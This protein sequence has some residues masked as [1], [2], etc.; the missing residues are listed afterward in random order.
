MKDA[1][2][3]GDFWALVEGG[4]PVAATAIHDGHELRREVEQCHKLG[5][6]DRLREEDPYTGRIASVVDTHIIPRRSRFEVDLNRPRE[7]AVYLSPADAWGLDLWH[8][9]PS[10]DFIERSLSYHDAFYREMDRILKGMTREF[11]AFVVYDVHSYNHRRLGPDAEPEHPDENPEVNIGTETMDRA[12]W[13]PVVDRFINDLRAYEA[14]G[15][16]LDVRE[17]VKFFGRGNLARRTHRLHPETG[18]VL[19]IE[20]RKSFMDD[21]LARCSRRT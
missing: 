20:F 15:R 21:G 6:A 10:P 9:T 1:H 3:G 12:R 14:G 11:G 13:A 7:G 17:N 2:G 8:E 19:A 4:G 18:C 5:G 16:R